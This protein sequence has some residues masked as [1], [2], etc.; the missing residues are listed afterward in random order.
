MDAFLFPQVSRISVRTGLRK[1]QE[2]SSFLDEWQQPKLKQGRGLPKV[3][4]H[5]KIVGHLEEVGVSENDAFRTTTQ[6]SRERTRFL[7]SCSFTG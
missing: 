6:R 1:A 3:S 7:G 5:S 4:Q 2:P